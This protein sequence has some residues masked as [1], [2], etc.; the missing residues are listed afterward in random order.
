MTTAERISTINAL[1]IQMPTNQQDALIKALKRE[2]LREKAKRLDN[3]V[4]PNT[5][6]IEEIVEEVRKVRNG[7]YA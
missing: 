7:R 6:N 2:V 5:M 4:T 3:T 1:V